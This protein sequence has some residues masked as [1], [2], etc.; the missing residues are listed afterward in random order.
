MFRV[1]RWAAS[2][3]TTFVFVYVFFVV[4]VGGERTLWEHARRIAGT[5]E[6]HELGR[7]LD[8]AGRQV[9]GRVRDEVERARRDGGADAE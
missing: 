4:P 6:A 9:A 3:L 2:A 1:I 8:R 5:P 7:D